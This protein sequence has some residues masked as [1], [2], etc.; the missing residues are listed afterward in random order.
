MEKIR[1]LEFEY[2]K[3]LNESYAQLAET[4]FKGLRRTLPVTKTKIDWDKI[5]NY[6]IG[7]ALNR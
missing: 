4:T 1:E 5:L 7:S 6:K 3:A 2:Q